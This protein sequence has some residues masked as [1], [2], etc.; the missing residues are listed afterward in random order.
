MIN[1][2]FMKG[3]A[4]PFQNLMKLATVPATKEPN[5]KDENA[6]DSS[7]TTD[8]DDD[9]DEDMDTTSE[10]NKTSSNVSACRKESTES[11]CERKYSDPEDGSAS[12][13]RKS[14]KPKRHF[15]STETIVHK[16]PKNLFMMN[17]M[18]LQRGFS[19]SL[20]PAGASSPAAASSK[21]DEYDFCDNDDEDHGDNANE[22]SLVSVL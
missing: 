6:D 19:D 16:Q 9:K 22:S 11:G 3:K 2:K 8:D 14:E 1:A 17:C 20:A 18:N 5:S 10:L 13:R 4:N 21:A 15:G 7:S 12:K